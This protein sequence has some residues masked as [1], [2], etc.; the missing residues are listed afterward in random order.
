MTSSC[1]N[2]FTVS[3]DAFALQNRVV[4][5]DRHARVGLHCRKRSVS[6]EMIMI[7]GDTISRIVRMRSP[8]AGPAV[9]S[10]VESVW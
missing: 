2:S 3:F 8:F 4:A 1:L 7:T 5:V 9:D 10:W 6:W